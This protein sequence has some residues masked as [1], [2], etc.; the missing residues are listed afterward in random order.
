MVVFQQRTFKR[1]RILNVIYEPMISIPG[2]L[3][4][5]NGHAEDIIDFFVVALQECNTLGT[6]KD[7]VRKPIVFDRKFSS[8]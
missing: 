1:C 3:V 8:K 2:G 5:K 7:G 4:I 6:H